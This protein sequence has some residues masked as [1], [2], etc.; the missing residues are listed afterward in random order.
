MTIFKKS[1]LTGSQW[2]KERNVTITQ[3]TILV[4]LVEYLEKCNILLSPFTKLF[5]MALL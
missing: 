2:G 5:N 3:F 1:N 4:I